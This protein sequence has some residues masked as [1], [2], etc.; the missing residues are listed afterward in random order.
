M[1]H[2]EILS[3]MKKGF[4]KI[5]GKDG[6]IRYY[7]SPGRVNLIG[8][9]TDYN[10]GHVL[11]CALD[12]GTYAIA[13]KRDDRQLHFYSLNFPKLGIESSLDELT[14]DEASD[15]ANYPKGVMWAFEERGMKIPSG[16]D[17]YIFGTIPNGSGLSSSASLEVLTGL[18]LRD[19]FDF[20]VSNKELAL[21]GQYAE[22]NFNK[23]NSGIMDQFAISMG[24]ADSAIFLRTDDLRWNYVPFELNNISLLITNTNKKRKLTDSKYNERREECEEALKRIQRI[25][26]VDNLCDL[27]IFE[28]EKYKFTIADEDLIKRAR[29]VVYENARTIDACTALKN[30]DFQ[31]FG[32]MM[33]DSHNSL[34]DDFEVTGLELDTLVLAASIQEGVLGSRMTGAGFGGCTITLIETDKV[35]K[36]KTDVQDL[37]TATVGYP[38]SFYEVSIGDGPRRIEM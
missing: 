38:C 3:E 5:Y 2:I 21:I 9:H 20:E 1:K 4:E 8:E 34:K 12:I 32:K 17:F 35:E 36:F 10:G 31:K 16:I 27:S 6:D 24:K 14:P 29:H 25:K 18:I 37:Y 33:Y 15:W 22:N 19:M 28:F 23:V 7:F 30:G 13:K 11:P 26:H